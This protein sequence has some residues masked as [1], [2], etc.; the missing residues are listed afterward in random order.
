MAYV[1]FKEEVYKGLNQLSNRRNNNKKYFNLLKK[2]KALLKGYSIDNSLSYKTFVNEDFG[3]Q[4]SLS[5][6]KFYKIENTTI[7]SSIF[8]TCRFN[9]IHFINCV[10]ICCSFDSCI[11]KGGGTL[12]DSCSFVIE[13][14]ITPPTLNNKINISTSFNKCTM[15]PKFKNC[16]L[17]YII[18]ENS[19]LTNSSFEDS[20]LTGVIIIG[21]TLK[22]I[23]FKDCNLSG[24]KFISNVIEDFDFMDKVKTKLDEK[25]FFDKIPIPDKTKATYEGIYMTYE[26]IANKFKENSLSNNFGEYYYLCKKTQT[27]S[28]KLSKRVGSYIGYITCGYG[29]RPSFAVYSSI[30]IILVFS[31]LYLFTGLDIDGE[32][33][34]YFTGETSNNFRE[35]LTH[36][37]ESL[38]LS[39]SMFGSVGFVN[40]Q[41]S[42]ESY[43][44][45]C[46][47]VIL[48]IVMVGVGVGALIRKIIR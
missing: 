24:S 3:I 18:I 29:E 35:F 32:I 30:V 8:S 44:V 38:T 12:F 11:F 15:Y 33:V 20:D 37:N 16:N 14:S 2:D 17:S 31:I 1:N 4:G 36:Y 7:V 5:E 34:R 48:G 39:I 43:M 21:S 10:F 47:E 27:K 19:M 42:P 22:K 46:S 6:D 9:N 41:P 25:T 45:A 13:D 28:L 40:S 23:S 26:T